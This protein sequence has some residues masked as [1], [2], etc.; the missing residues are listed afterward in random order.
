MNFLKIFGP[1][2]QKKQPYKYEGILH[3]WEDDYLM[4]EILSSEN[5]DFIKIER[6]STFGQGHL[7]S[8]G[9]GFTDITPIGTRYINTIDKL[10]SINSIEEIMLQN[11]LL[12]IRQFVM[13]D[14][15]LL[16]GNKAPIGYG[17]NRYA[18]MCEAQNGLLKNIWITGRPDSEDE[19][20]KLAQVLFL[21]NRVFDSIAVN[22]FQSKYYHLDNKNEIENFINSL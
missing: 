3:L 11:S 20:Q 16:D 14:I 7:N 9:N 8:S 4:V 22:W 21:I 12:K 19:K 5:L 2:K 17:T 1:K 18:I 6:I 15:G 10:I 13:Q